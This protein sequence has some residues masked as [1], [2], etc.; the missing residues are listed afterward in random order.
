MGNFSSRFSGV[1]FCCGL[2][3]PMG[4]VWGLLCASPFALLGL[5]SLTPI[6]ALT[7]RNV[8]VVGTIYH[9][10]C[11]LCGY[12]WPWRTGEPLPPV[13]I[14]P[15]LIAKGEER[16]EQERRQWEDAAAAHYLW[17]QQHKK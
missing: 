4:M 12:K 3:L 15:D 5:L 17:Q 10:T 1:D 14:R 2:N 9:Y 13:Q 11:S 8:K 16:L 7:L 6:E